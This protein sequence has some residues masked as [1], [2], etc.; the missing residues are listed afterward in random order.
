MSDDGKHSETDKVPDKIES[1][2]IIGHLNI[3]MTLNT[4]EIQS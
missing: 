1:R 2:G 3:Q 4:H